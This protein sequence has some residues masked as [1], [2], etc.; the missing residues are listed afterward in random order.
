MKSN[1]SFKVCILFREFL[2]LVTAFSPNR[3]G[4]NLLKKRG[5][6]LYFSQVELY[7]NN[8]KCQGFH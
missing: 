7:K 4:K 3:V 8:C 6:L 5:F 1:S 2:L